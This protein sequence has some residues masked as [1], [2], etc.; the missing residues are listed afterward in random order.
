MAETVV[1]F[2]NPL[3][4]TLGAA[5]VATKVNIPSFT[6]ALQLQCLD[7]HFDYAY[8]GTDGGALGVSLRLEVNE[9]VQLQHRGDAPIYFASTT[10]GA[11][12]KV[13]AVDRSN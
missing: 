12:V 1:G 4:V 3:A 8:S 9:L 7:G 10:A 2:F 13:N 5:N 11:V 6:V